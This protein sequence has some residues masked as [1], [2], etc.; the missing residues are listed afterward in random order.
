MT[1]LKDLT[2]GDR[3]EFNLNPTKKDSIGII[4]KQKSENH[5][6]N[7]ELT[8]HFDLPNECD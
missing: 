5:I 8:M 2:M 7:K 1:P 3:S 6:L 4:F